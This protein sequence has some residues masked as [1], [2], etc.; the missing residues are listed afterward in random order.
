MKNIKIWYNYQLDFIVK[1]FLWNVHINHTILQ[2]SEHMAFALEWKQKMDVKWLMQEGQKVEND[3]V[4]H[5]CLE[6]NMLSNHCTYSSFAV[7]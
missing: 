6:F 3:W 4:F 2:E 5:K 1:V 7:P